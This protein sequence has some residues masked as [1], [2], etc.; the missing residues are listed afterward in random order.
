MTE[1]DVAFDRSLSGAALARRLRSSTETVQV[2]GG[3]NAGKTLHHP[4]ADCKKT[5]EF[6]ADLA[7][8]PVGVMPPGYYPWCKHCAAD[9]CGVAVYELPETIQI[10]D[11]AADATTDADAETAGERGPEADSEVRSDGGVPRRPHELEPDETVYLSAGGEAYHHRRSCP[12]LQDV[13]GVDEV[14]PAAV[15]RRECQI[16][17]GRHGGGEAARKAALRRSGVDEAVIEAV[18]DQ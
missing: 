13:D 6:A 4:R 10:V 17:S 8:K 2:V 14:A 5:R 11:D 1:I 12:A 9:L 3:R 18:M 7:D 16:C 15:D